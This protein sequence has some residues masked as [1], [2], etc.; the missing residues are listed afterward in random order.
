MIALLAATKRRLKSSSA[1]SSSFL[2]ML[3]VSME[4][5]LQYP[6]TDVYGPVEFGYPFWSDSPRVIAMGV[7]VLVGQAV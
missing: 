6:A 7:S 2:R 4:T 1:N 3:P 5:V